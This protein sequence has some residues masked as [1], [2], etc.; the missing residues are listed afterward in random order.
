MMAAITAGR[1]DARVTVL[2]RQDRVGKNPNV[3]IHKYL[4]IYGNSSYMLSMSRTTTPIVLVPEEPAT[5]DAL[6]RG[7]NLPYRK[8]VRVPL[9]RSS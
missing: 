2:E 9:R 1:Q 6:V 8:V 5:L 4:N 7:R 3:V